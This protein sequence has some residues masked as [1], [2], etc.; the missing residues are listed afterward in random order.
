M[1]YSISI[2]HMKNISLSFFEDA[3]DTAYLI[4]KKKKDNIKI[5]S[6]DGEKMYLRGVVQDNVCIFDSPLWQ[7]YP[8][9][10][11]LRRK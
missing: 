6:G 5:Y 3:L 11:G 8:N 7:P 10:S 1:D 2:R 4:E 9:I